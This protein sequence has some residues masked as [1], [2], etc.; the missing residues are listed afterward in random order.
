[1]EPFVR[2]GATQ[3]GTAWDFFVR[4]FG[5]EAA[6][7]M[8]GPFVSGVYAGDAR[9]LGARASFRKFW[10]FENEA[11]SMIVGAARYM[12]RK[13]RRQKAEGTTPRRGL[14]S[15]RGGI[16]KISEELA[17]R[18]GDAVRTER[19]VSAVRVED[20]SWIVTT[21]GGELQA[22]SV[23]L[24]VPPNRASAILSGQDSEVSRALES[25]PMAPV[26]VVNWEAQL[27]EHPAPG[28]GFLVPRIYDLKVLG[29][30]FPTELFSA[31]APEGHHLFASFYGGMTDTG[32]AAASDAELEG[33]VRREHERLLGIP[34][35]SPRVVSIQRYPHAIPQMLPKHP[36]VI[37]GVRGRLEALPGLF[38]AGNYLTGVGIEHAVS[39]GF[40]AHDDCAA[41][42][43]VAA[44]VA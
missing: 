18:L 32:R 28:F 3:D 35:G 29:T 30:L 1:M 6:T 38:L 16:G 44:R 8:M 25:I 23:V 21:P 27:K 37:E 24:A 31:R 26:A 11:G 33:L 43:G 10:D 36:E 5:E 40:A 19:P 39:S 34:Y 9:M 20:G 7:Y 42:L 41:F 22:Q 2:R 17:T 4:R 14:F 12:A 13:R 15:F